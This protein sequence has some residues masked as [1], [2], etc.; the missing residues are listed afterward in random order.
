MYLKV[1]VKWWGNN[2]LWLRSTLICRLFESWFHGLRQCLLLWKSSWCPLPE[3][4]EVLSLRLNFKNLN[5]FRKIHS[6][7][8]YHFVLY[9]VT[10]FCYLCIIRIF[11][12][13][14]RCAVVLRLGFP[15][16]LTNTYSVFCILCVGLWNQGLY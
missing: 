15:I 4:T 5:E 12:K 16:A 9:K 11:F 2:R 10:L 7:R 1:T 13:S 6:I 8:Q 3:H 14:L